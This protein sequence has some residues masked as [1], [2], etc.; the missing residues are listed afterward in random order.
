VNSGEIFGFLGPNGAGK[1]TTISMLTTILKPTEG[2]AEIN[3]LDVVKESSKVRGIIGLVPQELT[4]DD[5]LTGM[6]NIML[7]ATLYHIPV[8]LAKKRAAEVLDLI[9]LMDAAKRYV[10]TYSGGMRKRLELASGLIHKPKVLFL[11]EPTLGLDV[12]TRAAIWEYIRRLSREQ[13]I[14]IFLTTHYM[15]EAEVLCDRLAIIDRGKIVVGGSPGELKDMLGGDI[16]EVTLKG[17]HEKLKDGLMGLP[18]VKDVMYKGGGYR[19]KVIRGEEAI[20]VILEHLS[21]LGVEV[22]RVSLTKPTLDQVFLEYTGRRLR[23]EESTHEEVYMKA[24]ALRRLRM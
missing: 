22:Q 16:I 5:E 15:E 17:E 24:A 21:S 19:I 20:P 1:T 13:N 9:G 3:G 8:E 4:V 14:T 11:D 10:K 18:S 6:E 2:K 23:D 12:Q 7:Q